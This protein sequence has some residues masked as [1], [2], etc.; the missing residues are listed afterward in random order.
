VAGSDV[1]VVGGVLLAPD[2]ACLLDIQRNEEKNDFFL[3]S[4]WRPCKR[5]I[6]LL[7]RALKCKAVP[8]SLTLCYRPVRVVRAFT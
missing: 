8:S 7:M 4:V 3:P 6:S 1:G 2:I 5:Q